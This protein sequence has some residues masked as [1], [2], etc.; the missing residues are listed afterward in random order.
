MLVISPAGPADVLSPG[1][2]YYVTVSGTGGY[3]TN[4]AICSLGLMAGNQ[5]N[6]VCNSRH[7]MGYN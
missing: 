7:H 2:G 6:L 4:S 5:F 3:T 1:N